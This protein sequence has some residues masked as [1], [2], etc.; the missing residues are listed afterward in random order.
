MNPNWDFWFEKKPSGNPGRSWSAGGFASSG[1][2]REPLD[3]RALHG[4]SIE[5]G[6]LPILRS[7][8]NLLLRQADE[9]R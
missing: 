1:E 2:G 4:C 8:L 5:K 3:T 6:C 7:A 9:K